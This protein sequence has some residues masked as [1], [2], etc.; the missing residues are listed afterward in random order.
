MTV[1]GVTIVA[2]GALDEWR[3]SLADA[4]LR[5]DQLEACWQGLDVQVRL[6]D[7]RE[8]SP[9][10]P[11]LTIAVRWLAVFATAVVGFVATA[12][13]LAALDNYV[14]WALAYLVTIAI[15]LIARRVEVL[16]VY[17]S[18][19]IVGVVATLVVAV[20]IIIHRVA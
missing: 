14:L 19:W 4:G 5:T 10:D 2:G 1:D 6:R 11:W 17:A 20:V 3:A 7:R 9:P 8:G 16:C 18:G 15:G 12:D 13:L